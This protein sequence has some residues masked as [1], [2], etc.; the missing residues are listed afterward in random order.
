[1]GLTACLRAVVWLRQLLGEIERHDMIREPT[2]VY[3]DNI[4]A[5]R[6]CKEHFVTSGNQHILMPYH[7]NGEVIEAKMAAIHWVQTTHNIS[8]LMS[9]NT[10]SAISKQLDGLLSGYE[11]IAGLIKQLE[12][13]PRLHTEDN[14]KLGGVSR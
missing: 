11:D 13:S 4:Q 7:W 10:N 8:D 9:K 3:G 6:L 2:V 1:M 12:S 14:H 5:N